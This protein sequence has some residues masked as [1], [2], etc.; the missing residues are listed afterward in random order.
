MKG[1][2][3]HVSLSTAFLEAGPK[4]MNCRQQAKD[5]SVCMTFF[6]RV[7]RVKENEQMVDKHTISY[8]RC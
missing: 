1:K 7:S 5:G 8:H 3:F 4:F 2:H 6:D